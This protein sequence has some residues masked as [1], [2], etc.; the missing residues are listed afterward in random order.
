M[1]ELIQPNR[2]DKRILFE[3]EFVGMTDSTVTYE[4]LEAARETLISSLDI[5]TSKVKGKWC[6]WTSV[7]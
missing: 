7:R 5:E 3:K 1:S 2:L 4:E 6:L